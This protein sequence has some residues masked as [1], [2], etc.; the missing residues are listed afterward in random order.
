MFGEVVRA[1]RR[2]LGLT[3]EELAEAAGVNVRTIGKIEANRI[4]TP[5]PATVRLLADAFGL[6]GH[7]RDQ[8]CAT[9]VT[10]VSGPASLATDQSAPTQPL[11]DVAGF[12]DRARPLAEH[13]QM[14]HAASAA[15]HIP[16][17]LP[18]DARGFVGRT[19]QL[20]QLDAILA[21][22]RAQSTA[23]VVVLLGGAGMGKTGLAVHWAHGVR[24]QFVDGQL[25][26]NLR[27]YGA[28]APMPPIEA[29]GR[30]LHALGVAPAQ[31]P[32]E[33]DEAAA[34]YRT[35]MAD[36]RV[37]VLLDN[38]HSASQVR[39]LLPASP[40]CLVLVTARDHMA[41]LV[42]MEDALPMAVGILA[43]DDARALLTHTLGKDRVR[44]EPEATDELAVICGGLPLALR[45]AAAQLL[46][47][48][49]RTVAEYVAELRQGGRVAALRI[50]GDEAHS[51]RTAFDA[52][53][54]VL[55]VD[56]RRLFRRLG[57]I[58]GPDFTPHTAAALSDL[59]VS[60][61][62]RLLDLLC[63]AHLVERSGAGRFTFHDLIREYAR[64]RATVEETKPDLAAAWTQLCDYYL[65]TVD[66]AARR[67]YPS[68]LRLPTP[69][70]ASTTTFD[71]DTSAL[72]W[73]D[74]EQPNLVAA[75]VEAGNR[76]PR[77]PAWLLADALRGHF[78]HRGNT[79]AWTATARCAL[80]AA[81]ESHD[82]P[83]QA[84]CELSLGLAFFSRGEYSGAIAH[85]TSARTLSQ[86]AKWPECEAAALGN[87]GMVHDDC[88]QSETAVDCYQQ[89]LSINRRIGRRAAQ[90][91]NVGNLGLLHCRRGALEQAAVCYRQALELHR[92]VGDRRY[93]AIGL[94]NLGETY[95]LLGQLDLALDHAAQALRI[96]SDLGGVDTDLVPCHSVL[97]AIHRDAGRLD[98]ALAAAQAGV[99]LV[100]KAGILNVAAAALNMLASVYISLERHHEATR[101]FAQALD[102]AREMG[103]H[104]E[105]IEA[106]I[107]LAVCHAQRGDFAAGAHSVREALSL[108][109]FRY[110]LHAGKALSTLAEIEL[111]AGE[112]ADA[113]EHAQQALDI[114][115]QTGYRLGQARSLLTLA[116]AKGTET[117]VGRETQHAAEK[118]FEMIGIAV[119]QKTAGD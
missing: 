115:T 57:L 46:D 67:L 73:L 56:P 110:H 4:I 61:A 74:S 90:A 102:F 43:F 38:A 59:S 41:G 52:S 32:T 18:L 1:H 84:A 107:G 16:A 93:K 80:A 117:E 21:A 71:D 13:V 97:A 2:R 35:L 40:G 42:A 64:E 81:Q 8:F 11:A 78:F 119:P 82:L 111:L 30:F 28:S 6:R 24:N 29:V 113:I 15:R 14:L 60:V 100:S 116:H 50:H 95:Q 112:P 9:A 39:P 34:L 114:Q 44:V 94:T 76:E 85:T 88:G 105:H 70:Q 58:P 12:V 5:R 7:D 99:D 55:S 37:L 96:L 26:V 77:Q 101:Y 72:A 83:A 68:H 62:E 3:Q 48:P 33:I 92:E 31:V 25:H 49:I 63:R 19:E 86:V 79:I 51:V 87:L 10:A 69:L 53:Y 91:N 65:Q 89:A 54:N 27:G 20:G 17:Q 66:A 23:A 103:H 106:L 98:Q 118:I 109:N 108:A 22:A 45:I 104:H 75:V 36:R 47:T